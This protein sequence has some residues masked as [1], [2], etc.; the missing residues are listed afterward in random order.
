MTQ[1]PHV[2]R[3]R[4]YLSGLEKGGYSRDAR[5]TFWRLIISSA[6]DAHEQELAEL[7]SLKFA[8]VED[9]SLTGVPTV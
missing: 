4:S 2:E 3:I 6:H 1:S 9:P 7:E 8:V 5:M